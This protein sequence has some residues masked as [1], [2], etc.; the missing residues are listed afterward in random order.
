MY[1]FTIFLYLDMIL[2]IPRTTSALKVTICMYNRFGHAPS[3]IWIQLLRCIVPV[4]NEYVFLKSSEVKIEVAGHK[5][6]SPSHKSR[7][8]FFM[9]FATILL[10]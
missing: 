2:F 9:V 7:I 1:I 4:Y 5:L 10:E 6:L 3:N 8:E